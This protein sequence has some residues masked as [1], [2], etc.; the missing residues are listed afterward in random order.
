MSGNKH[1]LAYGEFVRIFYCRNRNETRILVY[2]VA[3][4]EENAYPPF[5]EYNIL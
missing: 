4:F 3:N 5:I 2:N 1:F